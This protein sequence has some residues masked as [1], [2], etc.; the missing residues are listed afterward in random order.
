M[1][2]IVREAL[3]NWVEDYAICGDSTIAL[4]WVKS[5]KLKLSLFHRNRVVQIRRTVD[6][7]KMFHVITSE[8]LADLPTRP[9]RVGIEDADPSSPWHTGL[10]WMKGDLSDAVANGI[11]TPLKE[12]SMSDEL[13]KEFDEGLVFEKSKDILTKGHTTLIQNRIDLVYSRAKFASYLILP[14][15]FHFPS[16]VRIIGYVYKF[17]KSFKCLSGKL[18]NKPKFNMFQASNI[19]QISLIS[20]FPSK[21]KVNEGIYIPQC[22]EDL[23]DALSYL[24]KTGT[25]E[26]KQFVKP[27]I[28]Q[29][30]TIENE[31][32]LYSKSRVMDG[33]RFVIS[34]DM[35]DFEIL[36]DFGILIR[37]PVIERFS[38]LAYSIAFYIHDQLAKHSGFETCFRK[39]LGYCLILKGM[40]L[41][42]E[43]AEDCIKCKKLRKKFIEVSMGPISANQFMIAPPFWITQAD[44]FGP[45]THYVPGRERNTRGQPALHCKCYVFFMVC[46]V[47]KLSNLQVIE[48]KDVGGICCALTRLGCEVG[49]PKILLVDGE[50]SILAALKDAEVTLVDAQ[51]EIYKEHGIKFEKCPVAGHNAHGL[52]ERKIKTAQEIFEKSDFANKRLHTTGLQTLAKLTENMMNNTPYGFSYA[53]G[54]DNNKLMK[55]ITPN[56][57]RM[58]RVNSRNLSGP[59]KLPKGPTTMMKKVEETYQI[60]YNIY[61][62]TMVMKLLLEIQPKWFKSDRDTKVGDVV[63]FR[64][65]KDSAVKGSWTVGSIEEVERGRDGLIRE[66]WI[67]YINASENTPRFTNRAIRKVV[68]LFNIEDGHWREDMEE[69]FK[70]LKELKI[71]A[72]ID[73]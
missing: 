14:T 19:K 7:D 49:L 52:V 57:M 33:Q 64:K 20:A 22:D 47:T 27:E 44:L 46:V 40:G 10:T 56:M 29:K 60:F 68:K 15:K 3:E 36:A 23:S 45:L 12:L 11:L 55:L 32:I 58:G 37:T 9:D 63:F 35:K 28:L 73:S 72:S 71:K 38:P 13:K 31:E 70:L 17:I 24:F 61:N 50:S 21:R 69:V 16:I 34:G 2:F 1:C 48:T 26:V 39:S 59:I 30:Q 43:L 4:Q 66:V 54:K 53:R 41:F 67:R 18:A 25:K 6:L 62:D 51:F 65:D 42:E 5:D 8:N